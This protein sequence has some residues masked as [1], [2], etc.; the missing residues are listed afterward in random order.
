M[1][2]QAGRSSSGDYSEG[3]LGAMVVQDVDQIVQAWHEVKV[4]APDLESDD[5]ELLTRFKREIQLNR[6]IKH[7]NTR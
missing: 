4:L 6:K 2:R 1:L 5:Q 3:D 7:P